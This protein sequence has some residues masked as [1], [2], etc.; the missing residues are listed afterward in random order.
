MRKIRDKKRTL[1]RIIR[2]LIQ[3][4]ELS[5]DDSEKDLLDSAKQDLICIL[6]LFGYRKKKS[7]IIKERVID[8]YRKGDKIRE[9]MDVCH[10]SE[11]YV[12]LLARSANLRRNKHR[13]LREGVGIP[14][15]PLK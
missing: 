1:V 7:N 8:L 13:K 12:R 3:L 2:R 4:K 6:D 11:D 10:V 15:L 5:Y 14:S 9:I